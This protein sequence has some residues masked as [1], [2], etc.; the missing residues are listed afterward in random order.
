MVYIIDDDESVRKALV[1]LMSSADMESISCSSVDDFLALDVH[2][3]QSCV[4]AD[5]EVPGTS[6]LQLPELLAERHLH[7]PVVFI[8]ADDS[9]HTRSNAKFYGG[10]A[11]F[12]KPVD[13]Q[14]LLDVIAWLSTNQMESSVRDV[15]R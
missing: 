4:V 1:R 6:T 14:A 5:V 8:T 11:Y 10:A 12:R 15:M 7:L 13:G 9:P 2:A 3:E